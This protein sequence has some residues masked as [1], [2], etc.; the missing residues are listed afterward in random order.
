MIQIHYKGYNLSSP[1]STPNTSTYSSKLLPAQ[2]Q[3][4]ESS[5]K[6][7]ATP[8]DIGINPPTRTALLLKKSTVTPLFSI[9]KPTLG[10]GGVPEPE[11]AKEIKK[12]QNN[13]VYIDQLIKPT[14]I[15]REEV[16]TKSYDLSTVP[17]EEQYRNNIPTK[18]SNK[19]LGTVYGQYDNKL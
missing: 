7:K 15:C 9:N 1:N 16:D 11:T 3:S 13:R 19:N 2:N 6:N 10:I 12:N 5:A 17:E 8:N 14:I 4:I 18:I